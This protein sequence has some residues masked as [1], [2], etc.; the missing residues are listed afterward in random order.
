MYNSGSIHIIEQMTY[1]TFSYERCEHVRNVSYQHNPT[2]KAKLETVRDQ[3]CWDKDIDITK[4]L[5]LYTTAMAGI[6]CYPYLYFLLASKLD[7][8]APCHQ[9]K[10]PAFIIETTSPFASVCA[11]L[12]LFPSRTM[13]IVPYLFMISQRFPFV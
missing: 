1:S 12:F 5:R 4:W 11:F 10:H 3:M 6:R 8:L 13:S 7:Q 2:L 9:W